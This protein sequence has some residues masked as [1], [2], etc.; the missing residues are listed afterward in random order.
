MEVVIGDLVGFVFNNIYT[1][2]LYRGDN[3][4]FFSKGKLRG[5]HVLY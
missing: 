2:Q 3:G 5:Y 1:A 4:K